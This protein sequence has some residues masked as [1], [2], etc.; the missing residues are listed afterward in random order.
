MPIKAPTTGSKT[1]DEIG[2]RQFGLLIGGEVESGVDEVEVVVERADSMSLNN[3]DARFDCLD[4]LRKEVRTKYLYGNRRGQVRFVI[5]QLFPFL[6][7][8]R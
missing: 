3:K 1:R 2:D 6:I 8:T 4:M 7:Q 5:P